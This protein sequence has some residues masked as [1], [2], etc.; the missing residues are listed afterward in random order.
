[1]EPWHGILEDFSAD[2]PQLNLDLSLAIFQPLASMLV[3]RA[4]AVGNAAADNDDEEEDDDDSDVRRNAVECEV[5]CR[6]VWEWIVKGPL[7]QEFQPCWPD[8]AFPT[9]CPK[10]NRHLHFRFR[11][12][13]SSAGSNEP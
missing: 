1:M 10:H 12:G 13:V 6:A 9:H 4:S 11:I 5:R 3:P 7:L 8:D 2:V